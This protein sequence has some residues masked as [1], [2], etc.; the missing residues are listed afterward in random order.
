MLL[1]SIVFVLCMVAGMPVAFATG[2]AG[3]VFFVVDAGMP[4]SIGVQKIASMSQSFPLLA[5]PFFVL[6]GHLMNE[7]GITEPP[8]EGFDGR[9]RL[10]IGRPGAGRHP[11]VH[12]DGRGI[13]LCGGR[14]GHGGAHPG[15]GDD[16]ER[17]R[18]GLFRR[19]HRRRLVDHRDHPALH[20]SHPLRLRRQRLDRQAVHGRR[21]PGPSD[22]GGADGHGLRNRKAAR[23]RGRR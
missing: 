19:G 17:L 16:C 6:A 21:H 9:G 2:I 1:I 23:L 12:T 4:L 18:Q 5:V 3:F 22:D 8:A 20:R 7:S 14:R 13:R 10:D 11:A 15:T